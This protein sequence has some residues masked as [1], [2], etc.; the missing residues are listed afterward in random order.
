MNI[1]LIGHR[2]EIIEDHGKLLSE[3]IDGIKVAACRPGLEVLD[4][5]A[6]FAPHL[7]I[8]QAG[9]AHFDCLDLVEHL[10]RKRPQIYILFIAEKGERLLLERALEAG[11]D[12]FIVGLPS[13]DELILRVRR[14]LGGEAQGERGSG[15]L[16]APAAPERW[17][18]GRGLPAA[19]IRG[20]G[21]A[22]FA[23]LLL[24]LT[25][26][27]FFLIQGKL[28]GA[29]P[30]LFGYQLYAVLSGSM[31]PAFDT[32]SV[33]FVRP[34]DPL[35]I[36]VGDVI[37][38]TAPAGDHLTTHRVV[39]IDDTAGIEFTTRG[40][41]NNVNDPNPVPAGRLVG[42]VHGA[43]PYLGYLMGF[44]RTRQGL[45]ILVFIPAVLVI[46]FEARNIFRYI[47]AE[48]RST[49]KVCRYMPPT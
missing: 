10:I 43:L 32:G 35:A 49:G 33:L 31:S 27:A 26:A 2:E 36:D 42:R 24:L 38:F 28:S 37:T 41:A 13:P 25:A 45:I 17:R 3:N 22:L 11:V 1:L 8:L 30:S 16:D 44:V 7:V 4:V 12:D 6:H 14:G 20:A 34:V 29:A 23:V 39:D 47:R 15:Q 19:V 40:D 48:D 21:Q 5:T 18:A 9:S 46:L